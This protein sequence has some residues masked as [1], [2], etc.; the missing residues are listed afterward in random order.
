M[1]TTIPTIHEQ[2]KYMEKNNQIDKIY[3]H[4]T[5]IHDSNIGVSMR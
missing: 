5:V 3:W 4:T 2:I 1:N